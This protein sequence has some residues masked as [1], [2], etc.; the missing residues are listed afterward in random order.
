MV[1][2]ELGHGLINR[3]KMALKPQKYARKWP[4]DG[5]F[6]HSRPLTLQIEAVLAFF[7]YDQFVRLLTLQALEN[8]K[9]SRKLAPCIRTD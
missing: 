4:L 3:I 7:E 5:L 6:A 2:G 9:V 1:V 8:Q